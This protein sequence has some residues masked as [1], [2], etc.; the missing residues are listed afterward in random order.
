MLPSPLTY[1]DYLAD[2]LASFP[3]SSPGFVHVTNPH[4][5]SCT[6]TYLVVGGTPRRVLG[7]NLSI[8]VTASSESEN[9]GSHDLDT[10]NCNR[11]A[12]DIE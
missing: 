12:C 3:G 11:N 1:A 2:Y 7:D 8:I 6:S 9:L 5:V 4:L 10:S